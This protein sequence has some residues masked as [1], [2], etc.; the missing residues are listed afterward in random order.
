MMKTDIAAQPNPAKNP[1]VAPQ[2]A[3][4]LSWFRYMA[5]LKAMINENK[6]V[7][8]NILPMFPFL[9]VSLL[10]LFSFIHAFPKRTGE[11]QRPPI[12]KAESDAARMANQL[13]VEISM[14]LHLCFKVQKCEKR[15]KKNCKKLTLPV[16]W[17][18]VGNAFVKTVSDVFRRIES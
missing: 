3:V 6:K 5:R 15:D 14:L 2:L 1:A 10:K 4:V 8:L 18:K 9:S 11:Y 13:S 12:A 16:Q 7:R 17:E